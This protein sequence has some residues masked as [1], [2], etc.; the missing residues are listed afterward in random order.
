[1]VVSPARVLPMYEGARVSFKCAGVCG[2]TG[3]WI[4]SI[5]CCFGIYPSCGRPSWC[6]YEKCT[7]YKSAFWIFLTATIFISHERLLWLA[8]LLD[9][10]FRIVSGIKLT[11]CSLLVTRK[12]SGWQALSMTL[13]ELFAFDRLRWWFRIVTKRDNEKFRSLERGEQTSLNDLDW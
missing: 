10:F 9:S 8:S 3:L 5:R 7:S 1:M 6:V 2:S 13:P 4:A 12:R 11:S